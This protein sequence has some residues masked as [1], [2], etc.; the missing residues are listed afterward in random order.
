MSD[1]NGRNWGAI[2]GAVVLIAVA[3]GLIFFYFK[4]LWI[5]AI[6]L[7]ILIFG[8]YELL[9]SFLRSNEADRWG[10][11]DSGA[12]FLF[13]MIMI[14]VGGALV[15]YQYVDNIIFPIVYAI[16]LIVIYLLATA[17]R[18]KSQ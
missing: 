8:A 11:S 12:A 10:T 6:G 5:P 16:A 2:T 14:A 7:P 17:M 3:V 1:E 18:K 15:I 4:G 9:T 13:G